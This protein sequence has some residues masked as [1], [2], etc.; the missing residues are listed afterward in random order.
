MEKTTER[1]V[2]YVPDY[3]FTQRKFKRLLGIDD[4][5]A[6]VRGIEKLPTGNV[7]VTMNVYRGQ[8]TRYA[9]SEA[10]FREKLGLDASRSFLLAFVD[11]WSSFSKIQ[12]SM[13]GR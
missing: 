4:C 11:N 1:D 9:M 2:G 13:T 6:L 10:E 3:V 8:R 7:V 5:R 12:I